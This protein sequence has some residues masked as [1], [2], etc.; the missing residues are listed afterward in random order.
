LKEYLL[1]LVGSEIYKEMSYNTDTKD[2]EIFSDVL[3]LGFSYRNFLRTIAEETRG[4][5]SPNTFA[6]F[7][8]LRLKQYIDNI[9]R[10]EIFSNSLVL[11][12]DLRFPEEKIFLKKLK[13]TYPDEVEVKYVY[14]TKFSE[15]VDHRLQSQKL[16][17]FYREI[18]KKDWIILNNVKGRINLIDILLEALNYLLEKRVENDR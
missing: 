17:E 5:F 2:Q 15:M 12:D 14:L 13:E 10:S 11:I 6:F 3:G 18:D 1:A 16:S 4:N 9:K 7:L 8:Y